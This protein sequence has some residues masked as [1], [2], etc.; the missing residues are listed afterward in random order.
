MD[1]REVGFSYDTTLQFLS[2]NE[3]GEQ[4]D[5]IW[6]RLHYIDL[7]WKQEKQ[8]ESTIK[9]QILNLH[10]LVLATTCH[11]VEDWTNRVGYRT[12]KP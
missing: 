8:M 9:K 4:P 3:P 6:M 1:C 2:K 7:D 12:V 11:S 10:S 5:R